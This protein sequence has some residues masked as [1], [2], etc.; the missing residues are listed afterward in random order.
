MEN[1]FKEIS[2]LPLV[3]T[4]FGKFCYAF[5]KKDSIFIS[6]LSPLL[7][8]ELTNENLQIK[9]MS[10]YTDGYIKC[11]AA[12]LREFEDR[13]SQ[14]NADLFYKPQL[15]LIENQLKIKTYKQLISYLEQDLI[16]NPGTL[17]ILNN[18]YKYINGEDG[19]TYIKENYVDYKIGN[20][21]YSKY[22]SIKERIE[23]LNLKYS[24][25]VKHEYEKI[26]I[27]INKEDVQFSK[28]SLIS[29]ND[30]IEIFN[31]KDSQTIRDNRIGKHFWIK[32]PRKLLTS[33]EELIIKKY[34]SEISFRIDYVSDYLP[35]MEEI[36]FGSPLQLKLSSLP[37]LSKFY[38][39]NQYEN[40]LWVR[41]DTEKRSLTFEEL[42]ADFEVVDDDI[43]T[44]VI[45]LEYKVQGVES[46]I[47]H[48]DHEFIIYTLDSYQERLNDANIK[49]H[50]KI[51][52]FKIDNAMIPFDIKINNELF[53][54]QV[55]DSY[56]KNKDLIQE[57]F[58]KI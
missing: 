39:T 1:I 30:N 11:K 15:E 23:M 18:Y 45:H 56:F 51:K 21:L 28:Y 32:V 4:N 41:H 50:K 29:L 46:F 31:D 27:D 49:G 10:A 37:K 14:P 34:L 43:V 7:K 58:E 57:Y 33:I 13:R 44:Q 25:V 55:L 54:A 35:A 2:E 17:V 38:S 8:I 36:E 48:L 3:D 19:S 5:V 26:S 52:T 40:N 22:Q 20:I 9:V 6:K 42:M 16:E 47:T 24:G 12:I 53:L